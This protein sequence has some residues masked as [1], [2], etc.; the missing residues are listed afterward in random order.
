MILALLVCVKLDSQSSQFSVGSLINS[1][2][3]VKKEKVKVKKFLYVLA[4]NSL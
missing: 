1:E 4:I 2:K 3:R